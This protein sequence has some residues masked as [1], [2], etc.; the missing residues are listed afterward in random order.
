MSKKR[1]ASLFLL[2]FDELSS[3][4]FSNNL[5]NLFWPS[6]FPAA[7]GCTVS[8]GKNYFFFLF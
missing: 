3:M 1:S 7:M 4:K 2:N 6:E 5:L 8:G